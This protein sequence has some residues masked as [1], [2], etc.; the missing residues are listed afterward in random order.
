MRL[1]LLLMLT[2]GAAAY[3]EQRAKPPTFSEAERALFPTDAR[4]LL[5][6]ERP[7]FGAMKPTVAAAGAVEEESAGG[8]YQW[9]LLI[10]AA[11]VENEIK[12]QANKV[13]GLTQSATAFKGGGYRKCREAFSVLAVMFA[14]AAEHDG[15]PRW[16]DS[17]AGL[18][19]LFARAGANCK[20]GTD[21]SYREAAA[22][23]QD[24]ADLVRGG[25]P[26][27]PAVPPDQSW[28][29]LADRAPLMRRMEAA[30]Q[31]KLSPRLASEREFTGDAEEVTHEAQ[32][33]AALAEVITRDGFVDA[34]DPDYAAYARSLRD[35]SADLSR[36]AENENYE[37][38]RSALG[39][40][41]QSCSECHDLYRG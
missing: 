8:D 22:R 14:V 29:D 39:R 35:A 24:L 6:G 30:Q 28:G 3:A 2:V 31:E 20:V 41:S 4:E 38:G 27:A 1:F 17:A 40:A 11:T 32:V 36:A 9:S 23:S 26:D 16:R 12:R 37:S 33:L 13:A 15:E 10:S 19:P 7:D 18:A 34:D 5:V 21:G 25:R